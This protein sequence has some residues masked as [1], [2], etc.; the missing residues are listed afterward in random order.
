MFSRTTYSL[1]ESAALAQF[2]LVLSNP[3]S[4]NITLRIREVGGAA[5]SKHIKVVV[6]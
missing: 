1:N 3:S 2:V 5:T 4:M 6:H